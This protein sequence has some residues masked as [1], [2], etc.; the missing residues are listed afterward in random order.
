MISDARRMRSLKPSDRGGMCGVAAAV[1]VFVN[2]IVDSFAG[3]S[4]SSA[5]TSAT[6][7]RGRSSPGDVDGGPGGHGGP[8]GR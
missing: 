3:P 1:A 7:D 8:G 4:G 5:E 6:A 2:L